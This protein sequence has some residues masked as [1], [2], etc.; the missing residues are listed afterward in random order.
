MSEE[1]EPYVVSGASPAPAPPAT[2]PPPSPAITAPARPRAAIG[3]VLGAIIPVLCLA[4][5]GLGYLHLHGELVDIRES[6]RQLAEEVA[7]MRKTPVIDVRGAPARGPADAVVTLIEF[8]DYECPFC[9]AHFNGTGKTIEAEYITTGKIRYV[10]RDLPI[11]DNHPEAIRA[12]IAARCADEQGRFW[13]MHNRLFTAP[14]THKPA[15]LTARAG[16]VGLDLTAF[17]SCVDS[18][19]PTED[20]RRVAAIATGF[21]AAGTPVFFLGLRDPATDQV[22]ILHGITGAQPY[23]TFKKTLDDLLSR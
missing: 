14:G 9:I 6:Q 3:P 18:G 15:D 20:I 12:H 5:F 16:E 2:A 1:R 17:Q 8:S 22:R 19:R 11:D 7:G 10:F 23:E 21:G 13:E 4:G